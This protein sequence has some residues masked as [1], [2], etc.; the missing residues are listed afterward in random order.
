MLERNSIFRRGA[1]LVAAS[2]HALIC[3]TPAFAQSAADAADAVDVG[4]PSE[5]TR[6]KVS[7]A[8]GISPNATVNLVNLL[9][10][11]GVLSEE[12]ARSLIDQAEKEAYVQR[13]A[14]KD[15]TAKAGD[16]AKT[17]AAASAAA[18]P[19]GVKHVTYVP[20]IVKR[21]LREDIKKDVM[22]QAQKENW[23]SPG[24]FP[25][26]AT[27][28]H[29][30]GDMRLRYRGIF[31]PDGNDQINAVNFNAI[32]TGSP[33]NVSKAYE[34]YYPTYN[35]TQDRSQF[36]FRGR[37][38]MIAELDDSFSV[39]LRFAGG[40]NNSP[41]SQNQTFGAGGGNFSKYS[42]WIDRAFFKFRPVEEFSITAGRMDNPFWS[43]TNLVWYRDIGFDG[44][45]AQGKY[46][47][48]ENVT[49]FASG[50]AFPLFN[51]DLNAGINLPAYD[52][53]PPSK[54]PSRDKWLFAGQL[55][56]AAKIGADYSFKLA[57]TYYDFSNV[58]GQL[59][60]PCSVSSASDLCDTDLTRPSFAQRGNTYFPLR[61]IISTIANNGNQLNQFQYFG[62][63]QQYRP[64][65]AAAQADFG[66][67]D[68]IHIVLDG[69][70]ILNTAFNGN[71]NT[72]F[73]ANNV[74][75][76]IQDVFPGWYVGGR[77]GYLASA[78]VGHKDIRHLWDWNVFG[79]YKYLGSDAMV[80]A[81]VDADFGLGGTNLKGYFLGG[82]LGVGENVWLA[83]RWMSANN[84]SGSPYA[85]DV[86]H[87]DLNGK[88]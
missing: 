87:L 15:A 44:F 67:F 9:V 34:Y 46:Q 7:K 33:Y 52:Y 40:E 63:A 59:S 82:N 17:A 21:Q 14:T 28:I 71:L 88:F 26:W 66:H 5:A 1:L 18:S 36:R 72:S 11:Q 30:Y 42:L 55:G 16:A 39:G 74:V 75:G 32:N 22:A 56:V 62:L 2:L 12:Q 45:A 81:F 4:K 85:A 35:V 3:A 83:L 79:G 61:S 20:E 80:D 25:E 69:E 77:Y 50:G 58:Q 53:G 68:P 60:T 23:A 54:L 65:V 38:G 47:V 49:A 51:T 70:Y 6:P 31:Y 41:V 73:L 10:K 37:L 78:T 48:A 19:P 76:A 29:F 43:P 64:V 8:R 84:I 24:V 57:A 13:Q 86:L 27:R